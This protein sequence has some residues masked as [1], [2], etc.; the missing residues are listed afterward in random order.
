[1]NFVDLRSLISLA[2]TEGA[3][4]LHLEPGLAPVLRVRGN[5]RSTGEPLPPAVS[6]EWAREMIGAEEWPRFVER[7]S[8]DLCR[9]IEGVRCRINIL[10]TLRGV[11]FAIRLLPAFQPTLENLN[12]H[13]DLK[14]L[15]NH[16]HGLILISG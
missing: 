14:N 15:V 7:R 13:P 10:H 8:S 6:L 5:L 4:D 12:L 11:G 16:H 3:S 9:T 1:M 2:K